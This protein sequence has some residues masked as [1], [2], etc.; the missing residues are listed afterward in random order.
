MTGLLVPPRDPSA[1][2]AA[3]ERLLA[4]EGLRRRLGAAARDAARERF[5]WEA[6][7]EATVASYRDALG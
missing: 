2:R 4:D 1:L 6:A 5:S 7:T 3:I